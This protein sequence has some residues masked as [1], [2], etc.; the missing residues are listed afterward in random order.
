[1]KRVESAGSPAIREQAIRLHQ[2]GEL[3][4][5]E[6]LYLGLIDADRRDPELRYLLAVLRFGQ[7]RFA[8][9]AEE[10]RRALR[11][12]PGDA[13]ASMLAGLA[14]AA[15]GR[16]S[17]A[18]AAYD[19]ALANAPDRWDVHV[20]RAAALSALGRPAEALAGCDRALALRPDIAE[21]HAG[22]GDALADLGRVADAFEAYEA[23][24]EL[25]FAAAEGRREALLTSPGPAEPA[26]AL[27]DRAVL[28][29]E[30]GRLDEA[31]A[32]LGRAIALAPGDPVLLHNFGLFGRFVPGHPHLAALAALDPAAL[33]ERRA[34]Y[35]HFARAKAAADL[36]DP[37]GAFGHL[38][39]GNAL[40][41]GRL[42][43][44]PD[45]YDRL[46]ERVRAVFTPELAG[47]P[48]RVERDAA[49]PVFVVGMPRSGS[50]L[51]ERILAGHRSV[52]SAGEAD[53]FRAA[54]E[55]CAPSPAAAYPEIAARLG[56]ADLRRLGERYRALLPRMP[57]GAAAVVDKTLVNVWYLGLIRLA[58][59][60]ARFIHVR[61]DPVDAGLSCFEQLFNADQPFAYDLAEIGRY[62]RSVSD[63]M[64]HW[65]AVLPEA[66]LLEIAYEDL[67][68]DPERGAR[69]LLAHAGLDWDPACL[70]L[71]RAGGRVGTASVAQVRRPVSTG[72]VGR[73]RAYARHLGPLLDALGLAADGRPSSG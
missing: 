5:A 51:V 15:R 55:G 69:R 13:S 36:G 26:G 57:A 29:A 49:R 24:V 19:R 23:A 40:L 39:R 27:N 66:A 44:D 43:H 67:V 20:N 37:D 21:A 65:R 56:A 14:E 6:P 54:L 32:M 35:L 52:R 25:G 38:A 17:A 10:A 3:A 8:E 31:R 34:A 60:E 68:A 28:L 30:L 73:W 18:V 4:A 9:A 47:P 63:V 16:Y 12:R 41:R 64:A 45:H 42:V 48:R 59:P 7:G 71:G 46:A 22:R 2:A 61:R 62:S 70:D 50:T 33:G 53:A 11:L 72:S 1:M 58:L